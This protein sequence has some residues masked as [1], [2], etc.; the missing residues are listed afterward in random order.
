MWS[1]VIIV[2]IVVSTGRAAADEVVH[3][4]SARYHVGEVQQRLARERGEVLKRMPAQMLTGYLSRPDGEGPFPAVVYLHGCLGLE[5]FRRTA[6]AER[7]TAWGYVTLVVDSFAGRGITQDCTAR[8]PA[9]QSDALGAL[10][11]LATVPLV[12]LNRIALVGIGQGGTAA[13]EIATARSIEIFE[14]P[15][16]LKFKAVVAFYPSCGAAGNELAAPALVLIGGI[17]NWG[18]AVD[19]EYWMR[20]RAGRGA[21]VMIEVYPEAY[22]AFDNP[23]LRIATRSFG[24]WVKY[25]ADA[26]AKAH[27]AMRAFLAA[28]LQARAINSP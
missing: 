5:S 19:C 15:P 4:D 6:A 27:T 12:D 16:E 14:L 10:R 2:I 28:E 3:F 11:Y 18:R 1:A 7:F 25:D 9:R 21:P 24:R 17:E 8:L 22:Y 13:L 20:R 26:T 23:D